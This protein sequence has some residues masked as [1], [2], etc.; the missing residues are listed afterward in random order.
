MI[1]EEGSKKSCSICGVE[2]QKCLLAGRIG[3]QDIRFI[4]CNLCFQTAYQSLME[5]KRVDKMF[6]K[7]E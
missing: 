1:V 3:E 5:K 4:L 2:A 6:D 7:G